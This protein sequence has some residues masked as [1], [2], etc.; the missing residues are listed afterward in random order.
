M[1]ILRGGHSF[2]STI[3]EGRLC[4]IS[5]EYDIEHRGTNH[6]FPEKEKEVKTCCGT[7]L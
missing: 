4:K 2:S 6:Y 7:I 5:N 1:M 3:I